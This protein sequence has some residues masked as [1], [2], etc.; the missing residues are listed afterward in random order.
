MGV[1]LSHWICDTWL[2]SKWKLTWAFRHQK[3]DHSFQENVFWLAPHALEVSTYFSLSYP[4]GSLPDTTPHPTVPSPQ[5]VYSPW[6]T[7]LLGVLLSC[8]WIH[9]FF[10]DTPGQ[11]QGIMRQISWGFCLHRVPSADRAGMVMPSVQCKQSSVRELCRVC[12]A[13]KTL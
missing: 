5:G 2:S 11:V 9:P 7:G 3:A 12:S 13:Q 8:A 10:R 1:V 6:N 4:S